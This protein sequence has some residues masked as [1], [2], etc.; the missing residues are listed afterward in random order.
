MFFSKIWL[1]L[2]TFAGV[3]ALG[4]LLVAT[5][6]AEYFLK[7]NFRADGMLLDMAQVSFDAEL[8]RESRQMLDRLGSIRLDKRIVEAAETQKDTEKLTPVLQDFAK[9]LNVM[10]VIVTDP[11]GAVLANSAKGRATVANFTP[12]K[13]A[14]QGYHSD[15]TMVLDNH[16]LQ[17]F[18]VPIL[19]KDYKRVAGALVVLRK[20]D[21]EFLAGIQDALGHGK[22]KDFD[23]EVAIF[24]NNKLVYTT[25]KHDVWGQ[26]PAYYE[27]VAAD[28]RNPEKGFAPSTTLVDK[29]QEYQV[30]LGQLRGEVT[31]PLVEG[32]PNPAPAAADKDKK[33]DAKKD[34]AKKDGAKKD[35]AKKAGSGVTDDTGVYYA[36]AWKLP[37]PLGSFAFMDKH[38]PQSELMKGFPWTMLVLAG[39][40]IF[41]LG[42]LIVIFE[43]D[44]PLRRL[45]KH[46]KE[47][48]SGDMLLINDQAFHGRF[49]SLARAINEALEKTAERQG[50]P[51]L[52]DKSIGDILGGPAPSGGGAGLSLKDGGPPPPPVTGKPLTYPKVK[53]VDLPGQK[54]PAVL[55]DKPIMSSA[56]PLPSSAPPPLPGRP[57]NP[58]IPTVSGSESAPASTSLAADKPADAG[59]KKSSGNIILP[60]GPSDDPTEY[61]NYILT[62]FKEM[63][64]QLE[65]S[66]EGFTDEEFVKKLAQSTADV[67]A[68]MKCERVILTVYER[69]KK[70]G[71][72]AAPYRGQ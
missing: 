56:P 45:I 42:M 71:L 8:S 14:V 50:G 31:N 66:L 64:M 54:V 58:A 35:G 13:E 69:E 30:I 27:K 67:R 21:T 16:L 7:Q 38:I 6:P 63:K 34:D 41:I 55:P 48:A 25:H 70:A 3:L 52:H 5:R 59:D 43:G 22:T 28:I 4:A 57:S 32:D 60:P 51:S 18:A 24:M 47:V 1:V 53:N 44:M 17:V 11:A 37:P 65:G 15:N 49:S 10:E 20:F 46:T 2:V 9:R 33:D 68:K 61:Y 36:L 19:S 26:V 62:K 40:G 12:F 23:V 72:K 29:K 39:V